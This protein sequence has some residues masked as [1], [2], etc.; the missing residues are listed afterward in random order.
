MNEHLDDRISALLDDELSPGDAASAR[1]H[2]AACPTC[3]AELDAVGAARSWLRALPAVDPPFGF[4]ERMLRRRS[5]AAARTARRR[6]QAGAAA[7]VAT[8]AAGLVVLGVSSPRDS[9]V[10]PPVNRLVEAHASSGPASEPVSQ[11][12]SVGVPVSFGR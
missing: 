3:R 8:A 6:W 7:V 4:Y 9:S 1:A 11:L 5:P 10:S 12:V 2:L